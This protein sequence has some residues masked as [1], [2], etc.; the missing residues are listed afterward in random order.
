MGYPRMGEIRRYKVVPMTDE[1][2][3]KEK[4]EEIEKQIE[5]QKIKLEAL[6]RELKEEQKKLK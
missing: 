3:A 2:I 5:K 4:I 1:D 6:Q